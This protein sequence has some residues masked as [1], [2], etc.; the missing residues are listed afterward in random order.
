MSE[1]FYRGLRF[2]IPIALIL[3]SLIGLAILVCI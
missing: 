2:A 3:W 1:N